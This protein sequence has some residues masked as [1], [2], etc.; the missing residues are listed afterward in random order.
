[1]P[2]SIKK[3]FDFAGTYRNQPACLDAGQAFS[4]SHRMLKRGFDLCLAIVCL[5]A[6]SPLLLVV[7]LAIWLTDGGPVIYRHRRIG[8]NGVAFDCLK[9]R[10]MAR[11]AD[12]ALAAHLARSPAARAE[13]AATRKLRDDPRVLGRL[14]R[15]LRRTSLDELPQLFNVLRGEMSLVGPRPI[16]REELVHYGGQSRWYLSVRPGVTGPWQVGGRSDTSYAT[17][18]RLDVEYARTPSLRRDLSILLQTP[19]LFFVGKGAY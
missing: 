11:D 7:A 19:R 8:R 16:V 6:F 4:P 15:F 2:I 12:R 14:G 10:T 3:A 5:L 17:R 18:V 13:W 1:M 9:F